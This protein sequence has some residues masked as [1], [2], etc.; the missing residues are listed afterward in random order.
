M[1]WPNNLH[2]VNRDIPFEELVLLKYAID[3]DLVEWGVYS[4]FA[5]YGQNTFTFLD[6]E[7]TINEAFELVESIYRKEKR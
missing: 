6:K 5:G 3:H 1:A 4:E 7:Y 2:E